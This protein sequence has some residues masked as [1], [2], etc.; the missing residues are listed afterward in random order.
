MILNNSQNRKVIFDYLNNVL[1]DDFIEEIIIPLFSS[2]GYKSYHRYSHGPGEKGKDLIFSK[3][4]DLHYDTEYTAVQAKAEPVTAGNVAHIASQLMRAYKTPISIK[5]GSCTIKPNYVL[6]INA[7]R[8]TNDA[9]SELPHMVDNNQNIKILQQENICD[10]III[11]G[12]APKTLLKELSL[13]L[14]TGEGNKNDERV[15]NIIL[16]NKPKEIEDLFEHKLLYLKDKISDQTKNLI[17]D[18]LF[19]QW[20]QDPTWEGIVKPL[21][22]LSM[23]FD[24]ILKDKYGLLTKVISEFSNDTP[25]FAAK[26]YTRLI[27]NQMTE[28]HY[29]AVSSDLIFR[30]SLLINHSDNTELNTL[31]HKLA[32]LVKNNKIV[33]EKEIEKAKTLLDAYN[34]K[35]KNDVVAFNKL[36]KEYSEKL[37][38]F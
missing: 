36:M 23:Y 4:I 38:W 25:S 16:D 6:L 22:W 21:R 20:S 3:D 31:C 8:H 9:S 14:K 10:L 29:A 28:D 27:I 33:D 34:A 37:I 35:I 18:Y 19:N 17:V 1:E 7:R 12:I 2:R 5:S 26:P 24:F 13:E 11:S 30:I 32:D 15:L